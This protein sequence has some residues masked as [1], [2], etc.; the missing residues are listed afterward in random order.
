VTSLT[1]NNATLGSSRISGQNFKFI[2][3]IAGAN[4]VFATSNGQITG[5]F[6]YT[7]P[8]G[9]NVI[10]S[11]RI[12][13]NGPPGSD[14]WGFIFEQTSG[15]S[16]IFFL[17]NPFFESSVTGSST[18]NLNSSNILRDLNTMRNGQVVL[19]TN[20]FVSNFN[21][22]LNTES[23]AQT[24]TVSGSNLSTSS[25]TVTAP[26]NFEVSTTGSSYAPSVSFSPSG[27]TVA[28][29]TVYLRMKSIASTGSYSGNVVVSATNA[30]SQTYSTTGNVNATTEISPQPV[31]STICS[32]NATTFSLT[33]AGASL[34]YQWQVSTNGGTSY[35]DLSNT[36]IY[37]G[38]TNSVLRLSSGLTSSYNTYKYRCN[39]TG[40]CG[41]VT[42]S[43]ASLT[44]NSPITITSQPASSSICENGNASFS[45]I[46]S[47]TNPVYQW[48]FSSDGTNYASVNTG[49]IYLNATTATLT[50]NA[51][52]ST[53]NNY[54]YRCVVTGTCSSGSSA[55]SSDAASL[56]INT[57]PAAPVSITGNSSLCSNTDQ[58]Y[59]VAAVSG[60]TAYTW[61]I[62]SG[63]LGTS[64]TNIINVISSTN[65]GDI[66]VKAQNSCGESSFTTKA[67]TVSA[68]ASPS[69]AFTINNQ[70]QCLSSNSF[71]FTNGST[72]ATGTTISGSSWD[73][74]DGVGTSALTSPSGYNYL[75]AGTYTVK[76]TVT[77][78]NN[79]TSTISKEVVINSAPTGSISGTTS[80]CQGN[81]ATLSV[82]LTG[83]G[84]W[85]LNYTD[86]N[87]PVSITT[88]SSTIS[89][90]PSATKTF[91]ITSLS[92]SKCPSVG[93]LTGSAIV[94]VNS[95]VVPS[96]TITSSDADN[97]ICSSSPSVTFSSS[98]TYGGS[99][100]SASPTYQ[101]LKNGVAMTGET[102]NSYITSTLV[103][104]DNIS[105]QIVSTSSECLT[106]N[107]AVSNTIQ[108]EVHSLSPVSPQAISGDTLQCTSLSN[109]VYSI[110]PVLNATSYTW[111][112]PSNWTINSGNGTTSVTVSL[113]A[114]ASSGSISVTA[115][116]ACGTSTAQLLPVSVSGTNSDPFTLTSANGTNPQTV[117]INNAITNIVY[118]T[119]SGS[120]TGATF[121]GLPTG[122]T[123][124]Y[125]SRIITISGTPTV[126]GTYNYTIKL[127]GG[128]CNFTKTGTITVTAANTISLSSATGTNVQTACI[129][130]PITDI[131]Y[132]TTG[133]TGATYSGLPSGVTGN[134]SSG[135]VT[136][137]G[138]PTVAGT[139][140]Y[141]VTLTGGCSTV[142]AIGTITV[143]AAK[144]LTL[145]SSSSSTSQTLCV[146]STLSTL[147]YN[148]T[149]GTGA[150]FSGLPLGVSGSYS[151]GAVSISGAPS[152]SGTFNYTV[153]ITGGCGTATETGTISTRQADEWTSNG[154][155]EVFHTPSNWCKNSVPG[156]SSNVVIP[157]V[158]SN[159]YPK[160]TGQ[161]ANVGSMEIRTDAKVNLNGRKLIINGTLSGAGELSGA[162]GSTLEFA[163]SGSI[164]TLNM[165]QTSTDTKTIGTL[166]MNRSDQTLTMGTNAIVTNLDLTAG[167]IDLGDKELIISTAAT[168]ASA[169]S[170]V[171]IS[172]IGKVKKNIS[173]GASF[174]FP[175]GNFAYN[176]I[177][178]T[179][180]N[181]SADDFTINIVDEVYANYNSDGVGTTILTSPR[182]KRTWNIGKGTSSN[183]GGLT[184]VFNWNADEATAGLTT[185]ALYHFES[186]T[187]TWSKQTGSTSY[188]STS[189]TY[190][191]YTGTF[192]PF[193]IGDANTNLPVSWLS[194]TATKQFNTVQLN[195]ATASETNTRD[196]VVEYSNNA[197]QWTSLSTIPAAGNSTTTRNYS[198]VHQ[199]PLKGNNYNYYRIL[200]RDIDDKFSYSKIVSIIF[201]EPGADLQ[202]YP[203]PV[204]DQLTIFLAETQ[205]VRLVNAAGA[206]VWKGQLPAG[207]NT[208]PVKTYSKGIYVLTAGMQ[209]Q[210][211]L[212]Q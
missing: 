37:T 66:R 178:I 69:A 8:S 112:F 100:P 91:Y 84:P 198:Y 206:T 117:C 62:P 113:G 179:N 196:F 106:T 89:V 192:S 189:L 19:T 55:V 2:G 146:Y 50:L 28:T 10:Y 207:R 45:V 109:Q 141:T 9:S 153:S 129:N 110:I 184:F 58:V 31:S 96:V 122:V 15:G 125:S 7:T 56:T 201:N 83:Q 151:S 155:T 182:V 149:G 21:T 48:E 116:N 5:K 183:S 52:T 61:E 103:D 25:I 140:S 133:A 185:P 79:C 34:T 177:T 120:G 162:S 199:N 65:S 142:T 205:L 148:S 164:G 51:A 119:T 97:S 107:T 3:D 160:L 126:A 200:Q 42:S 158:T 85:V 152:V 172:G 163:G 127:T 26:S 145:S 40:S 180:N 167:K 171:K 94:T 41:S 204:Q 102:S 44:V 27:G 187:N 212:I 136:L 186:G 14:V 64:T 24:F 67:V 175:V 60:A 90:T 118:S 12:D 16:L 53:Y 87:S 101:W 197:Q 191:G 77:A 11:G 38:A 165:D 17:T 54:K 75:A 88:S 150:I 168:N 73:Y 190:T 157:S 105:L 74:G 209:S 49:G 131:T 210:R 68:L 99:A 29:S 23:T 143:T 20:Y 86:A 6:I 32:G 166:K 63:W 144:T 203:N 156:A 72:A 76:L 169:S 114:S 193:A 154:N 108:T 4:G 123:G 115:S 39:V 176:P 70:E 98:V 161:D 147:T 208:I 128:T 30:A 194:F 202:V 80:I 195:W 159:K 57:A 47:G 170:Y 59:S 134:Y 92:D 18:L 104:E 43:A 13:L 174:T 22:C 137:S 36:G 93:G 111:T 81:T 82:S 95:N 121:T 188:T 138:T 35:S 124:S 46:T 181:S 78:S 135:T 130:T 211:V 139:Y 33:A 173:N 132:S 1:N 71:S